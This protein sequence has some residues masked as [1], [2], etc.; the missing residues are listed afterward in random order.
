MASSSPVMNAASVAIRSSGCAFTSRHAGLAQVLAVGIVAGALDF[1]VAALFAKFLQ[2]LAAH[3]QMIFHL[4]DA[5][6]AGCPI[7]ARARAG[8]LRGEV[9]RRAGLRVAAQLFALLGERGSFILNRSDSCRRSAASRRSS[10]ARSSV[11]ARG[12]GFGGGEAF[13]QGGEFGACRGEFVLL[14]LNRAAKL[15]KA[16]R[17]VARF[18]LRLRRG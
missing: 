4:R 14:G 6:A 13:V 15:R 3:A 8:G 11:Q 17:R 7:P 5:G 18:R 1:G 12:K 16:L 10:S 2:R 9:F